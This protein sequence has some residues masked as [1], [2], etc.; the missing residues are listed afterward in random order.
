MREEQ[1]IASRLSPKDVA[2]TFS[3]SLFE[4]RLPSKPR[5]F[6][7]FAATKINTPFDAPRFVTAGHIVGWLLDP[8]ALHKQFDKHKCFI[9]KQKWFAVH[10]FSRIGLDLIVY[11]KSRA[12]CLR[13]NI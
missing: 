6:F 2:E 3:A 11:I 8:S 4:T 10:W 13:P 1:D 9:A 12:S 5:R 7:I